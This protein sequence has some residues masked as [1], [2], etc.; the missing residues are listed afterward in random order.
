MYH[1]PST[2]VCSPTQKLS[3]FHW[4]GFLWRFCLLGIIDKII[5]HWWFTQSPFPP[6][7]RGLRVGLK[8]LTF[9]SLIGTTGNYPPPSNS[10]LISIK[11]G[12]YDGFVLN[13]TRCSSH[14]RHSGN[15]KN[16]RKSVPGSWHRDQICI[17]YY[18]TV[19][20]VCSLWNL[21]LWK[22]LP[23]AHRLQAVSLTLRM[24]RV[25]L[26]LCCLFLS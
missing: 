13:N 20:Q 18:I 17:S 21:P 8:I 10:H 23:F 12:G 1:P 11:T 24:Y 14:L 22:T 25:P 15:Y 9:Q 6:L 16:C 3:K 7:P 26:N 4:L 2:S 19:S 5:G